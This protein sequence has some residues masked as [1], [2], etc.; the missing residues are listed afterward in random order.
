MVI[1]GKIVK[2]VSDEDIVSKKDEKKYIKR[3]F[4]LEVDEKGD[5]KY[6]DQI[7]ME[8]FGNVHKRMPEIRVGDQVTV[9]FSLKSR[10]WKGR[11]F[12]QTSVI[13]MDID[14]M[15]VGGE[16]Y[17]SGGQRNKLFNDDGSANS[18]GESQKEYM[19]R[20]AKEQGYSSVEEHDKAMKEKEESDLPF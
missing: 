7:A 5:G 8:A 2:L 14:N 11:Y 6:V 13:F 19:E 17:P 4:L 20:L 15:N 18:Q 10:E 12:T 3:V 16:F 9:T 1:K